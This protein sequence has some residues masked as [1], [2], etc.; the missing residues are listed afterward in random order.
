[1]LKIP[2]FV[3]CTA[4]S[5]PLVDTAD[6]IN[7]FSMTLT[8]LFCFNCAVSALVEVVYGLKGISMQCCISMSVF[9]NVLLFNAL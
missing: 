2:P 6:N 8:G 1:M 9:Y 3:E 4:E 7:Y 5:V